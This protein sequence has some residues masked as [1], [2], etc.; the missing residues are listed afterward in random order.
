MFLP[1]LLDCLGFPNDDNF[2]SHSV[3][4]LIL[5]KGAAVG[6]HDLQKT[7]DIDMTGCVGVIVNTFSTFSQRRYSLFIKRGSADSA[8]L[9]LPVADGQAQLKV[10]GDSTATLH[11][12]LIPLPNATPDMGINAFLVKIPPPSTS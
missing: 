10:T 8:G 2:I 4:K 11:F 7:F 3:S 12:E 1:D 9:Q 6:A 5:E